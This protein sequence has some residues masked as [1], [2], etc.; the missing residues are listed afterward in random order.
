MEMK[1]APLIDVDE[2]PLLDEF[3]WKTDRWLRR[4]ASMIAYNSMRKHDRKNGYYLPS[5]WYARQYHSIFPM[6]SHLKGTFLVDFPHL[7]HPSQTYV[8]SGPFGT[9]KEARDWVA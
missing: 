9:E 7:K 2:L 5:G 8:D 3:E 6:D 1:K 4:R